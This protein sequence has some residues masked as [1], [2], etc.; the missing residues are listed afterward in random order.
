M[1]KTE[2]GYTL[3]EVMISAV[4]M[5]VVVGAVFQLAITNQASNGIADRRIV[6][7]QYARHLSDVL[8]SYVT[9]DHTTAAAS[10][11][12]AGPSGAAGPS[13]W[14]LNGVTGDDGSPI[15]DS[16]GAVWALQPGTHQLT[17]FLPTWFENPPL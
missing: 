8:A 2:G 17:H 5:A 1:S 16:M 10:M 11:N 7:N 14:Y 15:I 13:S 3:V 9:G 12:I 4:L 6:A